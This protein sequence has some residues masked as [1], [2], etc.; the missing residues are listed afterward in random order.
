ML[1]EFHDFGVD[2][3]LCLTLLELHVVVAHIRLQPA[4]SAQAALE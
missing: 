2:Q 1:C 4:V 3:A